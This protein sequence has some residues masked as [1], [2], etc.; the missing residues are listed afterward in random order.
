MVLRL[1]PVVHPKLYALHPTDGH[2]RQP[3]AFYYWC[4]MRTSEANFPVCHCMLSYSAEF[5]DRPCQSLSNGRVLNTLIDWLMIDWLIL[6]SSACSIHFWRWTFPIALSIVGNSHPTGTHGST[7]SY[8]KLVLPELG[9]NDVPVQSTGSLF[10]FCIAWCVG[11][12]TSQPAKNLHW[13]S[14]SVIIQTPSNIAWLACG[15]SG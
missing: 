13:R 6:H 2:W 15:S 5:H 4:K 11:L 12:C 9:L 10:W 8:A 3:F 7:S 14:T 1:S